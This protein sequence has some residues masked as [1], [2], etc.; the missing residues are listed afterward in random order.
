MIYLLSY[1]IGSIP[2]G[3]IF[4]RL[5]GGEDLRKIGSGN[6]GTTNAFR[7]GNKAIGILTLL[8]DTLKGSIPCMVATLYGYD[9][10]SAFLIGSLSVLGHIFPVWLKFKGGKGI[11]T[12]LGLMLASYPLIGVS[13]LVL[14]IVIAKVFKVSSLAG[15]LSITCAMISFF[16]AA[17]FQDACVFFVIF[18][19]VLFKHK[20]NIIRIMNKTEPVFKSK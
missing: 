13:C 2:F 6:I 14:W 12:T 7:T 16:V 20:D 4:S 17:H 19:I 18:L 10:Q 9:I 15:L 11:A 5:L 8:F 3:L 1:L